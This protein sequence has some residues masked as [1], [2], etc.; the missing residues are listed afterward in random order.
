MRRILFWSVALMDISFHQVLSK[1]WLQKDEMKC[2]TYI[3]MRNVWK[4]DKREFLPTI[5]FRQKPFERIMNAYL[6]TFF[7]VFVNHPKNVSFSRKYGMFQFSSHKI[8]RENSQQQFLKFFWIFH[9]KVYIWI[10]STLGSKIEMWVL[11]LCLP[12]RQIWSS[13]PT[14]NFHFIFGDH[15]K[16]S[17]PP[18][19]EV[20]LTNETQTPFTNDDDEKA[21]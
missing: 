18:P 3:V 14:S 8:W 2:T 12:T 16:A 19:L 13:N 10:F 15:R 5:Q 4:A 11:V 21:P 6:S 20:C 9:L 17:P 7:K 1:S